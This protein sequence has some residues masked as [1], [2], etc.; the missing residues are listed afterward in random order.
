MEGSCYNW[1]LIY[2]ENSFKISIMKWIKNNKTAFIIFVVIGSFA[3]YAII[4]F[5]STGH[6][7]FR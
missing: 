4:K 3:A 6:F 2:I 5:I 1:R 7:V